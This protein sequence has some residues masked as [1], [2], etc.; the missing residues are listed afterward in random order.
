[1]ILLDAVVVSE[2]VYCALDGGFDRDCSRRP[3]SDR[4]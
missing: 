1:M 3:A 4:R 2:R